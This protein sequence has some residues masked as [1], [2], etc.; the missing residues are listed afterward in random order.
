MKFLHTA[1]LHLGRIFHERSLIEDQR[2]GLRSLTN[3][4]AADDYAALVIAGDVYDRSIPAPEAVALFGAFL[5]ETRR[6]FPDLKVLAVPGNHDSADRLGF[7]RELFGELGIHIGSQPEMATEPVLVTRG[8]ERVAFFLL[9]FLS[10]GLL[11][12]QRDLAQE[13]AE[14]LEVARE[15]AVAAGADR[16]V[17][18]AHLFAQGGAECESERVFL[19]SAERVDPAL[20]A[21][22]DFVALGH[23]HRCQRV[24]PNAWYSGSPLAYSFAEADQEKGVLAVSLPADP[25]AAVAVTP[26]P[27]RPLRRL[28]RRNGRFDS[29]LEGPTLTEDGTDFRDDYLELTLD[30][31]TLVDNPLALLRRRFPQL[32]AVKQ[33]AALAAFLGD[34]ALAASARTGDGDPRRGAVEDFEFFLH[35]L[36]GSADPAELDLFR[37]LSAESEHAAQ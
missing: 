10:P 31:A 37:E 14:R 20:F 18:I 3:L 1:D 22:F 17:L 6:R 7:G 25:G 4:L 15:A 16:T 13:A 33:G 35:D 32:L 23:L 24:G 12:S 36:Y 30:D 8:G 26:L 11:R 27:L 5:A 2:H 28:R 19:G 34:T 21:K 29:F 9:P